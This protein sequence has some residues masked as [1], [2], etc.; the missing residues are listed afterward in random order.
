MSAIQL[1]EKF[2]QLNKLD[3]YKTFQNTGKVDYN[4][5]FTSNIGYTHS[6]INSDMS[7]LYNQDGL[8]RKPKELFPILNNHEMS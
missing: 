7:P 2:T 4:K 8:V 5:L 3:T 6:F 1:V